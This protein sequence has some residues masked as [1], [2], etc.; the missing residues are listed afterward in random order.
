MRRSFHTFILLFLFGTVIAQTEFVHSPIALDS[1]AAHPMEPK[2]GLDYSIDTLSHISGRLDSLESALNSRVDSLTGS[3]IS[4]VTKVQLSAR[5]CQS[6]IDS[7]KSLNLPTETYTAKMDSLSQKLDE[8]QQR[9]KK[10]LEDIKTKATT[11]IKSVP[12]P[13]ELDEKISKVTGTIDKLGPQTIEAKLPLDLRTDKLASLTSAWGT[14]GLPN[15]PNL[16]L[17]E[18]NL[19]DVTSSI[20]E[21]DSFGE[22]NDIAGKAGAVGEKLSEVKGELNANNVDRL[23]ESRASE[24]KEVKVIQKNV[25]ELPLDSAA[26]E[27][28]MK[29]YIK[30]EV[31]RVAVDHFT[32]KDQQLYEAMEKIAKYKKKY[33]GVSTVTNLKK[34][35]QNPMQNKPL[36]QRIVPGIGFQVQKKGENILLDF[37]PYVGYRFSGRITAGPGWNQRIGYG[38]K[39]HSFAPDTR[40]L[41]PRVFGEYL[42]GKGFSP[43]LEVELM[44]T[45][46][47]FN[48]LSPTLE[49]DTRHWVWGAF[50][51]LKKEYTFFR[52]VKGTATIMTRLFNLDHASPYGDVLNVRFGFE[53]PSKEKQQS[54]E[55]SKK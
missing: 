45:T 27:S 31:K 50:A 39:Q 46:L 41:G 32:G 17:P 24:L 6:K 5:R 37:N 25:T 48:T 20:K 22:V 8:V 51:G 14:S 52:R 15:V 7:L 53:F 40:I 19:R 36:A 2:R 42:L 21:M 44:N 49:P 43:R 35:P 34:R 26:S 1:N 16:N 4:T 30:Q 54:R 29:M 13:P 11:K 12:H 33:P 47:P 10:K 28:A 9:M 23:V 3:Y 38:T 18:S 55:R